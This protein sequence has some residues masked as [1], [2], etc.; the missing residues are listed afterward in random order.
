MIKNK[1]IFFENTYTI[2]WLF[3]NL[4]YSLFIFISRHHTS[5]S[6][7][8][9]YKSLFLMILNKNNTF[10]NLIIYHSDSTNN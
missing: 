10:F 4:D 1:L 5:L 8:N 7:T 3:S 2:Y 9:K 6:L